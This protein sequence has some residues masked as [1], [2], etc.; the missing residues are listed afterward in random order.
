MK[1]AGV[2][3]GDVLTS[4]EGDES[5]EREGVEA[6]HLAHGAQSTLTSVPEEVKKSKLTAVP[7]EGSKPFPTIGDVSASKAAH[8]EMAAVEHDGDDTSDAES[9]SKDKDVADGRAGLSAQQSTSQTL[10]THPGVDRMLAS[11]P[12][13]VQPASS[14]SIL[15]ARLRIQPHSSIALGSSLTSSV[16]TKPT[17]ISATYGREDVRSVFDRFSAFVSGKNGDSSDE[18]EEDSSDE[19]S[20]SSS[21][22]ER[23]ASTRRTEVAS[24]VQAGKATDDHALPTAQLGS[25][26]IAELGD[27]TAQQAQSPPQL[28][29]D[30]EGDGDSGSDAHEQYSDAAKREV[31][32]GDNTGAEGA[33]GDAE[34]Y[35]GKRGVA[36]ESDIERRDNAEGSESDNELREVV[37]TDQ[38]NATAAGTANTVPDGT[39]V[40]SEDDDLKGD[41]HTG[42]GRRESERNSSD[43]TA[44]ITED[45]EFSILP[46]ST[47][48]DHVLVHEEAADVVQGSLRCS[49]G[50]WCYCGTG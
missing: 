36:A 23:P 29:V 5:G 47:D 40:D 49:V 4:F 45:V 10:A 6:V 34:P 3:Y 21:G 22:D 7:A 18:D 32:V 8:P 26:S 12:P 16:A 41:Q 2:D 46:K 15:G 24:L 17:S 9:T 30:A 20:L 33:D 37:S 39:E 31:E 27:I 14:L 48:P 19:E 1:P 44:Q 13:R 28:S 43:E 25:G 38:G 11:S 42:G 50:R 35:P